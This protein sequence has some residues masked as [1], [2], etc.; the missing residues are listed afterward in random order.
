V[1]VSAAGVGVSTPGVGVA[2]GAVGVGEAG[3]VAVRVG[4]GGPGGVRVGAG[5]RAAGR[6]ALAGGVRMGVIV[7]GDLVRVG[8]GV[9]G[10]RSDDVV[11]AAARQSSTRLTSPA[12]YP[13]AHRAADVSRVTGIRFLHRQV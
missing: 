2:A 5:V 6:V 9:T 4:I 8:S 1:G 13:A 7:A 11:Q 10:T 12:P 3:A